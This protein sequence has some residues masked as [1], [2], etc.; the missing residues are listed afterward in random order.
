MAP[1]GM[2]SDSTPPKHS[3]PVDWFR[4]D[5]DP[6]GGTVFIKPGPCLGASVPDVVDDADQARVT[7]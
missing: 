7:E 6:V 5:G 4:R 2:V 1:D 3:A